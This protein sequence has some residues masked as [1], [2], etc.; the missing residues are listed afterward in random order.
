M[1]IARPGA[2]GSLV[3]RQMPERESSLTLHTPPAEAS[4]STVT[5]ASM[6]GRGEKR[7][8]LRG[9]DTPRSSGYAQRGL[10][11]A[12]LA[13][14]AIQVATYAALLAGDEQAD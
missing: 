2:I 10:S 1:W 7:S 11:E 14:A 5:S 6:R 3:A 13:E 8:S 4:P 12:Q 9:T